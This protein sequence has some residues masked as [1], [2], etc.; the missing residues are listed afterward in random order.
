FAYSFYLRKRE[1]ISDIR[2]CLPSRIKASIFGVSAASYSAGALQIFFN[3]VRITVKTMKTKAVYRPKPHH[4]RPFMHFF[5]PS[6]HC[7]D[8]DSH[9]VAKDV[10]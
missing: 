2:S 4:I 8:S 5:Q 9:F 6:P 7:S 1:L 3:P 10:L